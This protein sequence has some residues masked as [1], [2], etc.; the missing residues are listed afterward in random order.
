MLSTCLGR[1]FADLDSEVAA[2][3]LVLITA[4]H[5]HVDTGE[6][7]E[8]LPLTEYEVVSDNLAL[9]PTG[10]AIPPTG[11]AR[12]VHLH[13]HDGTTAT[14]REALKDLDE[15]DAYIWTRAEAIDANLFGDSEPSD[16]FR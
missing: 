15:P 6:A 3:T 10:E 5:D 9:T 8:G 12:N 7:A 13:L 16:L 11:S 4:D 2:E 1:G 14:V